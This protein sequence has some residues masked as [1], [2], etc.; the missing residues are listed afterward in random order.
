LTSVIK[1]GA[2]LADGAAD[3]A[4]L[5]AEAEAAV[6]VGVAE[7][8]RPEWFSMNDNAIE[9]LEIECASLVACGAPEDGRADDGKASMGT[10]PLDRAEWIDCWP[11]ATADEAETASGD[12]ACEPKAASDQA[13]DAATEEAE[14]AATDEAEGAEAFDALLWWLAA[15]WA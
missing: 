1:S 11:L 8:A 3:E 13:D 10:L 12:W 6:S 7:E 5:E 14:R 4:I 2:A 9:P 15:D